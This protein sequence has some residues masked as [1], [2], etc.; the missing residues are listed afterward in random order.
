MVFEISDV[1]VDTAEKRAGFQ[2]DGWRASGFFDDA[3]IR[4]DNAP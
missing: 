3:G 4:Q 2:A 1:G